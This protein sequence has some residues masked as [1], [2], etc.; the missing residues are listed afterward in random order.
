MIKEYLWW[1]GIAIVLEVLRGVISSLW[2]W[3]AI[4]VVALGVSLAVA[5]IKYT[6]KCGATVLALL[7]I[8]AFWQWVLLALG[9][10]LGLVAILLLLPIRY[11]VVH[12]QTTTAQVRYLFGLVRVKY[13][14]GALSAHALWFNLLKKKPAP[15]P[16]VEAKVTP[17]KEKPAPPPPIPEKPKKPSF[18]ERLAKLMNIKNNIQQVVNYPDRNALISTALWLVKRL[19]KIF[20]PTK[21][22]IA[23]EIGF[24]DPATTGMFFAA[25]GAAPIP[26]A[27][28][29]H[30]DL[31][32][33]FDTD[34]TII[35][36]D[37]FAKGR[38]N[39]AQLL[40]AL[41]RLIIKKEVRKL[42]EL[43]I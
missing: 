39:L 32:G 29:Q 21:L 31:A 24:A 28:R 9:V 33:N 6:A 10:L 18:K 7:F 43:L 25:Y 40:I 30:I 27:L 19:F 13:E 38:F 2:V 3:L 20:K 4:V 23:G 8:Y 42:I 36:L 37:I 35:A 41:I 12:N 17:Q 11:Q 34:S 22:H 5:G 15:A 1:I 16:K 14:N 26:H